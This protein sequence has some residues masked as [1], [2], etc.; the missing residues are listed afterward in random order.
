MANIRDNLLK[1]TNVGQVMCDSWGAHRFTKQHRSQAPKTCLG[2]R[3]ILGGGGVKPPACAPRPRYDL[4][5]EYAAAETAEARAVKEL[6]KLEMTVQA[7]E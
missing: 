5:A 4:W 6:D 3:F 2:P 1:G 7:L